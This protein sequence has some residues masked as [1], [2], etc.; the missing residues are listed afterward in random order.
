V[1]FWTW[2]IDEQ[3]DEGKKAC[4]EEGRG[5]NRWRW[6]GAIIESKSEFWFFSDAFLCREG[7][8]RRKVFQWFGLRF[9]EDEDD[10]G[11][12]GRVD[13]MEEQRIRPNFSEYE[14]I[15]AIMQRGVGDIRIIIIITREAMFGRMDLRWWLLQKGNGHFDV[16]VIGYISWRNDAN[17]VVELVDVH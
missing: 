9:F 10:G 3:Q 4:L 14:V 17:C 13:M 5:W 2:G 1:I 8:N 12:Y 6:K 7:M 16:V 15:Y 11:V